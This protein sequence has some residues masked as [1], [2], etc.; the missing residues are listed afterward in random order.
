MNKSLN[1]LLLI[2]FAL[3]CEDSS[4]I[5]TYKNTY[6]D[7]IADITYLNESFY[8]T[9]NDFS[10]NAGSQVDLLVMGLDEEGSYLNNR[11][12]LQLNGQGHFLL[13]NDGSE[14]F[15]QSRASHLIF[16]CS[17][18]GELSYAKYDTINT[19]WLPSGITYHSASDSLLTLYRNQ[20]QNSQYRLR[21]IS[22]DVSGSSHKDVL[23]EISDIDT[24][25]YGIYGLSEHNNSLFML[26]VKDGE[27]ALI[28][29]DYN[30]LEIQSTEMVGD[31]TVVGIAVL[32]D[33]LYLSFRDRRIEKFKDL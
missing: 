20:N 27:D 12:D 1:I 9:N 2:L 22:K 26:A 16:K 11:F 14:I 5:D 8:T 30:N 32:N 23:F 18:I 21:L 4:N 28:T 6:Y 17:V 3:S 24:T 31:S 10:G 7:D 25:Y 13:T 15:L 29:M 19:N 33:A